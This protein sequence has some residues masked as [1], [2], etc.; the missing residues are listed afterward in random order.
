MMLRR[1]LLPLCAIILMALPEAAEACSVCFGDPDHPMTKG[2]VAGVYVMI[3]F[4]GFVLTGIIS[5]ACFWMVRTR[6]INAAPSPA[7]PE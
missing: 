4:V 7:K 6:R 1:A 3:G 2:A 5:T